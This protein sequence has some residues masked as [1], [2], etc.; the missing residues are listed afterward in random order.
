LKTVPMA[1]FAAVIPFSAVVAQADEKKWT[2]TTLASEGA[3]AP[4]NFIRPE[5]T[6]DGDE[7][8]LAEYLAPI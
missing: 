8:D 3:F 1:A 7:I 4:Y 5:G 2:A 6:L